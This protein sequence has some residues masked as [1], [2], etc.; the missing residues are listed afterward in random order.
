[1]TGERWGVVWNR[2]GNSQVE[3]FDRVLLALPAKPLAELTIGSLGERPLA[4]LAN[5]TYPAVS[6]L[7]LGYKREQVAHP[8]DGFGVLMPQAEHRQVL[9]VLFSSS[10]FAGRAP[11]GH[12]ALTVMMGGI[13]RADLGQADASTLLPVAQRELREI[14]GVTG[15]PVFQ[16][17]HTWPR[18]IPQYN[19]GYGQYLRAIETCEA[20][21]D[22]LLIGGHVR[23]GISLTNCIAAGQKLAERALV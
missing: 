23:D 6:S 18:A 16:Q 17:L 21:H 12:V 9:G 1:M 10:L 11:D 13:H 22:G 14:L 5:I 7:F 4:E 8:L 20:Q 15:D 19:L 3:E 2:E